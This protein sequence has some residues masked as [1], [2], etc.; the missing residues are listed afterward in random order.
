MQVKYISKSTLEA[1]ARRT[2][3]DY[4]ARYSDEP[5]GSVPLELMAE[6]IGL[7]IEYACLSS[8][9]NALGKT[10]FED[11]LT[12]VYDKARQKY[13]NI[14]TTAGT[15]FIDEALIKNPALH[16]RYRY[17]LA[18]E[19]SHW[20]LHRYIFA[21]YDL[22]FYEVNKREIE[23]QADYLAQ[24]LLMPKGQVQKAFYARIYDLTSL[25]DL[26]KIFGVS[27]QAMGIRL[28]TLG[29]RLHLA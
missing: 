8:N 22:N 27:K 7:S 15:I 2:L 20:I 24:N 3:L 25:P 19:M 6:N 16:G 23:W 9:G 18:H 11:G 13:V 21:N 17:T 4:N 12:P 14:E 1:I 28:D 29:L 10:A 5:P 26:A